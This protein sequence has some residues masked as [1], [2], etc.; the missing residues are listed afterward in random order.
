MIEPRLTLAEEFVLLSLTAPRRRVRRF[1]RLLED[2]EAVR[3]LVERGLLAGPGGFRRRPEATPAARV[4]ARKARVVSIIRRAAPPTGRDAELLALLAAAGALPLDHRPDRLH[5]RIRLASIPADPAPPAVAALC[6][7]LRVDTHAA[8]A[9]RLLPAR[10]DVTDVRA[11]ETSG[12][13]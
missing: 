9:E 12:V 5:A 2:E 6:R 4:H 11:Q 7:E 1:A 13:Y 3:T 10:Q 8:L